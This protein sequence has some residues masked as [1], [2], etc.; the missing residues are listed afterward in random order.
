MA[1]FL[2][3]VACPWRVGFRN[4][5][6][7]LSREEAVSDN[8]PMA[9]SFLHLMARRLVDLLLGRLR[10]EH[11]KDVEIAVLRHQLNVLRRQVKRPEFRPA[12]R[13]LFAALSR[14]LPR[15]HWSI[16]PVTPGT[17]LRW[18]RRLVTRKWTQ[19]SPR[20]GRPPLAEHLVTR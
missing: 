5:A 10:S 13:A 12:D 2:G 11:A 4:L 18:H 19:P 9:L 3:S 20:G 7:A 6:W 14:A 15:S 17:I 8:R 1:D 16:F